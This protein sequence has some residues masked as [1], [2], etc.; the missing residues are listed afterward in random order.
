MRNLAH[1]AVTLATVAFAATASA[2]PAPAAVDAGL[3]TM[4]VQ[5]IAAS[6]ARLPA[7]DVATLTGAYP[8]SNGEMLHVSFEGRRLYATLGEQRTELLPAGGNRFVARGGAMA[9]TFDQIPFATEVVITG[10]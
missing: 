4:A 8:L 1:L 2:A 9:F 10:R 6:S 7:A 5:T 3:P